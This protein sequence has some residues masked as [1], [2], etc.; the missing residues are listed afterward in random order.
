MEAPTGLTVYE[1]IL[2]KGIEQGLERGLERG[3]ELGHREAALRHL[4]RVLAHR[5]GIETQ[6]LLAVLSR[7]DLATLERLLDAAL[8]AVSIDTFRTELPA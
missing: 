1:E 3:I 2:S 8:D 7:Y 4:L 5:F 6:S